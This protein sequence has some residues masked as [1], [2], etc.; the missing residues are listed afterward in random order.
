MRVLPTVARRCTGTNEI[1]FNDVRVPKQN[2]LGELNKAWYY[3][4]AHLEV[5]RISCAT[6]A[7][8][9]AQTAVTDAIDY[10]K[11][12]VQFAQPISKFQVI[13]HMLAD[14]QTEVAAAYLMSY[15][16]AWL[17]SQGKRCPKEASM[18]KLFATEVFIKTA[19]NAMQIWGGYAQMPESEVE[20]YWREAKQAMV[21][22]GTSQIL[23]LLIARELGL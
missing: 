17:K 19:T 12:R 1:F 15:R 18:A 7:T 16:L 4:L 13:Q 11:G 9:N 8:S 5:E 20:R 23:R 10:A 2:L 21:G 14:M 22:G 3:V 6:G